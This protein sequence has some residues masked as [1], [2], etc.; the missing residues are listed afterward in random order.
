MRNTLRRILWIM[1]TLL[2]ISV[3]A[4]WLLTLPQAWRVDTFGESRRP[5]PRFFEAAPPSARSGALGA[6]TD[7]AAGG[8]RAQ[9]GA[10]T[11]RRLGGAALPYVLPQ[12]DALSPSDRARVVLA[13]EPVARRMRIG[14]KEDLS[15]PE[16]AVL[17]WTRFWQDRAI[18]FRPTVAKRAVQR[19]EDGPTPARRDDV[20]NLDTFALEE[21]VAA[22]SRTRA[23][24]AI[25]RQR[26]IVALLAHVTEQPWTISANASQEE[27]NEITERWRRWWSSHRL[28]YVELDGPGRA[29]AM[30]T[31]TQYGRW[32]ADAAESRLGTSK[33]GEPV[34]EVMT[35]RAPWTLALIAAG[36]VGGSLLGLLWGALA[37]TAVRRSTARSSLALAVV[38]LATPVSVIASLA[39][40]LSSPGARTTLG[41]IVM[42]I[43]FAATISRFQRAATR[44]ALERDFARTL[45]ALGASERAVAVRLAK[46][47]STAAVSLVGTHLP[48]LITAAFAVEHVL[49]IPG[50]GSATVTAIEQHDVSFLMA[51]I[52]LSAATMAL[53]QIGSDALLLRLDPRVQLAGARR[54]SAL[55]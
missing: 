25:D 22:L 18:D 7:I 31:E 30:L 44:T 19:Y 11:L 13:L 34:L 35:T 42:C 21:L 45:R 5:L 53:L 4:F 52:L 16:S 41:A 14:T 9:R 50:L 43:V 40:P 10:L 36:L 27:A 23:T 32:A 17:F 26:R 29:L 37:A 20:I 12:L 55:E 15:S 39:P 1:P 28:D 38:L 8:A 6:L 24:E 33:S 49:G 48:S 2:S 51:L 54:G 47:A 3:L 46:G